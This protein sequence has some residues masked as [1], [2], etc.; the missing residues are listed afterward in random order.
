MP[1]D[2]TPAVKTGVLALAHF[3]EAE[4]VPLAWTSSGVPF[5]D[6]QNLW[7]IPIAA[8]SGARTGSPRQV[9]FGTGVYRFAAHGRDG[10]IAFDARSSER[11]VARVAADGDVANAV[12][13][14]RLLADGQQG[15][16]RASTT[17]DGSVIA[18]ERAVHGRW[19][20][21]T[22]GIAA[23]GEQLLVAATSVDQTNP[24]ISQDGSRVAYTLSGG[25]RMTGQGLVIGDS[26]SIVR[27]DA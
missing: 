25:P 20:V 21:W 19:E 4:A 2:G 3:R 23:G 15:A 26:R 14:V 11:V 5:S 1:I 17:R 24:A 16:W 10:R 8:A 7:S 18:F 13:P 22:K 27:P 12:A 9:T 6:G